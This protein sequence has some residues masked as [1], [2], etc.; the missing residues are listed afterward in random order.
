MSETKLDSIN[1]S[2]KDDSYVT[3]PSEIV[4]TKVKIG[5]AFGDFGANFFFQSV[6]IFLM[7]FWTDVFMISASA[8][9]LIFL[10]SKVWDAVSDPLMGYV[11]DHT[12]SRW[13]QKRPYLL[14]GAV[15]LG[16]TLFLLFAAPPITT[17]SLKIVYATFTF[18]AVCTM[19]TVVNVPYAAMTA[20]LTL[21]SRERGKLTS[22]RMMGAIIGTLIVATLT[23]PLV[24]AFSNQVTGFRVMGVIYGVAIA[25]CTLL[26]FCI[27]KER[28]RTHTEANPGGLKDIFKVTLKN[29]PF[30][31]LFLGIFFHYTSFL[32]FLA[33][34]IYFFKYIIHRPDFVAVG[35]FFIYIPAAIMLPVLSRVGKRFGKKIM[36]NGGMTIYAI[37]LLCLF[38]I[39]DYNIVVL[40]CIYTVIG[41]GTAAI[42]QGP[43]STMP[44]TVEYSEWKTGLRREGIIYGVFFFGMKLA[45]GFAAFL[46]GYILSM[47]G[48]V[49]DGNQTSTALFTIRFLTTI[50]PLVC[51]VIGAFFIWLYP[52]TH[53]FHKK[54]VDDIVDRI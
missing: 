27:V 5:Y 35:F 7:F 32:I 39:K 9:G 17:Y 4:P 31:F 47:G 34:V 42:Y 49:A 18:I 25:V 53:K 1:S 16:I 41:L 52:I 26:T 44:D 21:D 15:P 43:W 33:S 6:A 11:A 54:M 46:V 28:V 48:Y 36:F 30:I 12:E 13:G 40:I 24:A 45:A 29:K 23:K 22:F 51:F 14:F 8:A 20:N 3:P 38:F 19:Y 10:C 37:G 2:A 50:L